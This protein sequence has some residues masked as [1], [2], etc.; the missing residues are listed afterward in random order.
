MLFL[1]LCTLLH[2]VWVHKLIRFVHTHIYVHI[3]NETF[4]YETGLEAASVSIWASEL[5]VMCA[6]IS[7]CLSVSTILCCEAAIERPADFKARDSD[8]TTLTYITTSKATIAATSVIGVAVAVLHQ[9]VVQK[10]LSG[11]ADS[12]S[13]LVASADFSPR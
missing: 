4:V 3:E 1:W 7:Q 12:W 2:C 9:S 8:P 10:S 6:C 13:A 5:A 11:A